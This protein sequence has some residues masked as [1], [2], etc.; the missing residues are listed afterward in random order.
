MSAVCILLAVMLT[1][2]GGDDIDAP[3]SASDDRCPEMDDYLA[4]LLDLAERDGLEHLRIVLAQDLSDDDRHDLVQLLIDLV[5]SLEPGA[6]S[7][8]GEL[9]LGQAGGIEL[10]LA[11]LARWLG[12]DGPGA[13]YSDTMAVVVLGLNT[14]DGP[15]LFSLVQELL[16]DEALLRSVLQAVQDPELDIQEILDGLDSADDDPRSGLRALLHNLLVAAT[17]PE[18]DVRKWTLPLGLILDVDNPPWSEVVAGLEAFLVPGPRLDA[19]QNVITCLLAVDPELVWVGPLYDLLTSPPE[20]ALSL[21]DLGDG[22]PDAPLV[23]SELRQPIDAVLA[24][25][26]GD[27]SARQ[28]LVRTLSALLAPS[29]AAGVLTDLAALFE[30]GVI[31]GAV[32]GMVAIATRSCSP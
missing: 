22:D 17:K 13:P 8:M 14:C 10:T 32:E 11:S 3:Y 20:M 29:R 30:A 1:G 6:V 15:P 12:A 25:F 26:E 27:A 2:C 21:S 16:V 19:L 4:P 28:T 9:E 18:F 7:A 31:E 24:T 5:G 23:P